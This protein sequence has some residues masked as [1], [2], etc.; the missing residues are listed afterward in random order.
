MQTCVYSTDESSG[1]LLIHS[2]I[3]LSIHLA[4]IQP[5]SNSFIHL[6]IITWCTCLEAG[7]FYSNESSGTLTG[8]SSEFIWWMS[9]ARFKIA[10]TLVAPVGIITQNS[11]TFIR[12]PYLKLPMESV[13]VL[14]RNQTIF[15]GT[16]SHRYNSDSRD[17]LIAKSCQQ[18]TL[19]SLIICI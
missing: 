18:W 17:K 2:F 10:E 5:F 19:V 4:N 13:N 7:R 8:M 12:C 15:E 3:Q 9:L 11:F 1:T 14:Y 6:L 16:I